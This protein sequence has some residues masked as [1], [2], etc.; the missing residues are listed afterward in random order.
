MGVKIRISKIGEVKT[1][2]PANSRAL[3]LDGKDQGELVSLPLEYTIEGE[4]I[5]EIVVGN[6]VRVS[7]EIRNGV[8]VPGYFVTSA[9][10]EVN[11]K[12]FKTLNSVYN[13]KML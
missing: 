12:Q 5:G 6:S 3:H 4:L 8:K 13:Y 1:G 2:L 7:R 10:T 9:V 11:K